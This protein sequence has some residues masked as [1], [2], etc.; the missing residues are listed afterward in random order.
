MDGRGGALDSNPAVV[1]GSPAVR[2]AAALRGP[3]ALMADN[4]PRASDVRMAHGVLATHRGKRGG[5]LVLHFAQVLEFIAT[6]LL[7]L[8]SSQHQLCI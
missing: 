6:S 1:S 5:H 8:K 3:G 4:S 2:R 7:V